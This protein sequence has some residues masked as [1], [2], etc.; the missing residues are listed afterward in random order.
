MAD[1]TPPSPERRFVIL[2]RDPKDA[3]KELLRLPR[4]FCLQCGQRSVPCADCKTSIAMVDVYQGIH[5]AECEIHGAVL[6]PCPQKVLEH[7]RATELTDLASPPQSAPEPTT[8]ERD[9]KHRIGTERLA[10]AITI[11]AL[12][13]F[14]AGVI[15]TI[16]ST[17]ILGHAHQAQPTHIEAPAIEPADPMPRPR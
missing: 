3:P 1:I 14:L 4:H 17:F 15:L 7:R 11:A 8:T 16:A 10:A 6:F 2:P 9:E 5:I 12:I 13:G